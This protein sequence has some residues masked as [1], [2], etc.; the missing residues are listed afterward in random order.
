[1]DIAFRQ[2]PGVLQYF[3]IGSLGGL[4]AVPPVSSAQLLQRTGHTDR[5][6]I[7]V[8]SNAGWET[9]S[10][11]KGPE[12]SCSSRLPSAPRSQPKSS[13]PGNFQ[14]EPRFTRDFGT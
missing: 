9:P 10:S 3:P 12:L 14:P 4:P 5:T 6:S 2:R 8:R 7:D 13:H 11:S 1:M